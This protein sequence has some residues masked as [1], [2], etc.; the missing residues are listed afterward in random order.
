MLTNSRSMSFDAFRLDPWSTMTTPSVLSS[1]GPAVW[2]AAAAAVAVVE[3]LPV[4]S[5]L[6][7]LSVLLGRTAVHLYTRFEFNPA[8]GLCF[9]DDGATFA[10]EIFTEKILASVGRILQPENFIDDIDI[11]CT[12]PIKKIILKFCIFS[13]PSRGLVAWMNA[14]LTL[15]LILFVLFVVVVQ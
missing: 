9:I 11:A 12:L 8:P 5:E 6:W 14:H 4:F 1:S 3:E 7:K 13:L 15:C 2:V 10:F